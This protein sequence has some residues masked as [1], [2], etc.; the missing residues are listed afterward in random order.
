MEQGGIPDTIGTRLNIYFFSVKPFLPSP[1]F[2]EEAHKGHHILW[3]A[4][5]SKNEHILP[6]ID[7]NSLWGGL[8]IQKRELCVKGI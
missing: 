4:I 1:R 2:Q 8:N 5:A 6:K 7:K 3:L